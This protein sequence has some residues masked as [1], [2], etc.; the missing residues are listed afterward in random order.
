MISLF[1]T[2]KIKDNTVIIFI[3]P[4]KIKKKQNR[5]GI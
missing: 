3:Q 4:H 5:G 1:C 2:L